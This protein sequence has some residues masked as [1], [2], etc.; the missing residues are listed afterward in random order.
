MVTQ[1]IPHQ[2]CCLCHSSY[3]YETSVSH[4][5][6]VNSSEGALPCHS[7]H[8]LHEAEMTGTEDQSGTWQTRCKC[9]TLQAS[10]SFSDQI[11]HPQLVKRKQALLYGSTCLWVTCCV[12]LERLPSCLWVSLIWMTSPEKRT[13]HSI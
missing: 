4:S 2:P 5:T 6:L 9:K 10:F 11:S 13:L 1:H 7:N 8:S 3:K 12:V